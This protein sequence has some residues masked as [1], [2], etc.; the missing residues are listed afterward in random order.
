MQYITACEMAKNTEYIPRDIIM[1]A[2]MG[3]YYEIVRKDGT[4]MEIGRM[5]TS[6]VQYILDLL[7]PE[8]GSVIVRK[9]DGWWAIAPGSPTQVLTMIGNVP[10]WA[11]GGGGGSGGMKPTYSYSANPD[12]GG[13]SGQRAVRLTPQL[14]LPV[15]TLQVRGQWTAARNLGAK[16]F[17]DNS[18]TLG[19]LV[20]A[21]PLITAPATGYYDLRFELPDDTILTGG[22]RYWLIC[23]WQ[24]Q[25]GLAACG[26][27]STSGQWPSLAQN[28]AQLGGYTYN[29]EPNTGTVVSTG[30]SPLAVVIIGP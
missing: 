19:A 8:V 27:S 5:A 11:D 13:A 2:Q 6:N 22:T 23:W 24:G 28:E 4:V 25:T 20:A 16:I 3:T 18:G 26:A 1:M 12:G 10:G 17:L 21:T 9:Q 29:G 30:G 7:D 14:D 15:K